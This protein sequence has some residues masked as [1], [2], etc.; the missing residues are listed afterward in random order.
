MSTEAMEMSLGSAPSQPS[1]PQQQ[2]ENTP[3]QQQ[4]LQQQKPVASQVPVPKKPEASIDKM[5]EINRELAEMESVMGEVGLQKM[6]REFQK[7]WYTIMEAR[8]ARQK[9]LTDHINSLVE[10]GYLPAEL[11]SCW[12]EAIKPGDMDIKRPLYGFVQASFDDHKTNQAENQAKLKRLE[13]HNR[14]LREEKEQFAS[15]NENLK[16]KM[17]TNDYASVSTPVVASRTPLE[18]NSSISAYSMVDI[19]SKTRTP[20]GKTASVGKMAEMFD[21]DL[22]R[23]LTTSNKNVVE[24]LAKMTSFM[25]K[26]FV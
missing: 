3:L 1:Q 11:E 23:T 10:K 22:D 19:F 21:R 6:P 17:R 24:N 14:M 7:R 9:E 20:N 16:K 2:D 13:D 15:E 4:Q 18:E 25:N 26:H 8:E 12:K 5:E